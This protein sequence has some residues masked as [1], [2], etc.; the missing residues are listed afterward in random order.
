MP[1]EKGTL[2]RAFEQVRP[3]GRMRHDGEGKTR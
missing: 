1:E 2:K 3:Q